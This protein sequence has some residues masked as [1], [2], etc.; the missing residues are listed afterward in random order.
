MSVS[1][2]GGE[3]ACNQAYEIVVTRHQQAGSFV[4]SALM[5]ETLRQSSS[6]GSVQYMQKHFA[7]LTLFVE[8]F[9]CRFSLFRGLDGFGTQT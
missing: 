9:N 4:F 6:A 3:P 2:S 8:I 1:T 7:I 5:R